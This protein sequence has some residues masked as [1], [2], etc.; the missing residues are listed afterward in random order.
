M[1]FFLFCRN[2]QKDDFRESQ[3]KEF[4]NRP[5]M[6]KVYQWEAFTDGTIKYIFVKVNPLFY[7]LNPFNSHAPRLSK[8]P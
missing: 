5:F 2:V 3:C 4:D 6:G 8:I 7:Q 1:Y